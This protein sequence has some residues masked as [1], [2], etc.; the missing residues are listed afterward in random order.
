MS[1]GKPQQKHDAMNHPDNPC[2]V[3][4]SN[5]YLGGHMVRYLKD[6]GYTVLAFD[7][8]EAAIH[9][10]VPYRKLDVTR[11]KDFD[12]LPQKAA[13]IFY[14]AGLTGTHDGFSRYREYVEVNELGLL[15][16]LDYISELPVMPRILYPS[17]RLVYQGK[18]GYLREDDAKEAKTIYAANKIAAE[19]YLEVYGKSRQVPWS[20]CRIC[21]PYGNHLLQSYS[22]GTTGY[23][24]RCAES[25]VP[26]K[27]YGD[28]SL[29]RTFTHIDDVCRQVA[30][31]AFHPEGNHQVYNIG[32]EEFSLRDAAGHIAERFNV[33]VEFI[34]WPQTE[35]L[36]ES[37]DTVFDAAKISSILP[38]PVKTSFGDWV[39]SL[40]IE[41][42]KY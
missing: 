32:G 40:E 29:R 26:I 4:G 14:F 22:Y 21:V 17:T 37:G 41:N 28:G 38:D 10:E 33:P 5:G 31:V 7:L 18:K 2:V 9:G 35:L 42:N 30:A 11:R 8:Q 23:F 13:A 15:N 16:L 3:V 20:V 27:L 12:V 19:A 39:F 36:L 24:L 34:P 6:E 1:S 25:R